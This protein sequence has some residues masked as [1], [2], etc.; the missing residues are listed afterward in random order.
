M[1]FRYDEKNAAKL[2]EE[3]K[4]QAEIDEEK[5]RKISFGLILI[6]ESF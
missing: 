5:S 6:T 2:E 4:I 3:R 1:V